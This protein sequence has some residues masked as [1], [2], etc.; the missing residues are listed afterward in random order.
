MQYCWKF[1][2]RYNYT[3]TTILLATNK[4]RAIAIATI[5][6]QNIFC[7]IVGVWYKELKV[8]EFCVF[9][10]ISI[11]LKKNLAIKLCQKKTNLIT[12]NVIKWFPFSL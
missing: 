2:K 12:L 11:E 6:E 3:K 4:E 9:D 1:L 10:Y 5:M 7:S 8:K